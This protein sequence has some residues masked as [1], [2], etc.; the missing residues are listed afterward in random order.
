MD[1]QVEHADASG[2]EGEDCTRCGGWPARRGDCG[3]SGLYAA[4]GR[5][6]AEPVCA[7]SAGGDR[8]GDTAQQSSA[9]RPGRE[10][11]RRDCQDH[12]G[13][14]DQYHAVVCAND[15]LGDGD[16][17]GHAATY[18]TRQPTE[19]ASREIVSGLERSTVRRKAGRC[20]RAG[21]RPARERAGVVRP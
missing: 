4:H 14:S 16:R 20:R 2:V 17:Q 18:L 5:N 1:A 13:D 6:L 12:T 15:G 7:G 9:F 21:P 11:S 8:T 3:R 10:G 19:A